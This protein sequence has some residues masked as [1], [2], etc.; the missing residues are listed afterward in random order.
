MSN[1]D[2]KVLCTPAG[3]PSPLAHGYTHALYTATKSLATIT[4]ATIVM[5]PIDAAPRIR[6]AEASRQRKGWRLIG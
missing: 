4:H 2:P 6:Q 5:V 3:R 1:D